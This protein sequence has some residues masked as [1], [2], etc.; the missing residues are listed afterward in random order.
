M[1]NQGQLR[2]VLSY[3]S[4]SSHD[5]GHVVATNGGMLALTVWGDANSNQGR[6]DGETMNRSEALIVE[7]F[8]FF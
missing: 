2:A 4:C 7:V 8:A 1:Q 5:F 6:D 3:L